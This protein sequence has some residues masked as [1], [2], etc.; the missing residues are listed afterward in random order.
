MWLWIIN[1]RKKISWGWLEGIADTWSGWISQLSTGTGSFSLSLFFFWH[2]I[3]GPSLYARVLI[4]NNDLISFIF[5]FFHSHS[6]FDVWTKQMSI[7]ILYFFLEIS[8]TIS[9]VQ[10]LDKENTTFWLLSYQRVLLGVWA[11]N[12]HT[13]THTETHSML[14]LTVETVFY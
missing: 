4:D 6:F 5:F 1:I 13:H 10:L 7:I 12:T 8:F 9:C 14:T 2:K 3:K 11:R